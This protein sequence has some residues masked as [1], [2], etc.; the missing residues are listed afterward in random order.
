MRGRYSGLAKLIQ[1]E[2]KKAV[3]IWC[4]AH[5]LNLVMNGVMRCC[6]EIRNTLGLLEELHTFM[7]GH[8]RHDVFQRSQNE[9]RHRMQL[10]RVL[11]T[12]WN[13]TVCCR[14]CNGTVF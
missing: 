6:T 13:S 12:R 4:N 5:R 2:C 10:K 11:T 7:N 1:N 3:Y 14:N 9:C 8:R